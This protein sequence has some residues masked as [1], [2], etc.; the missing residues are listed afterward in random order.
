M[1]VRI[2]G[3]LQKEVARTIPFGSV[4]YTRAMFRVIALLLLLAA[5]VFGAGTFKNPIKKTDGSDPYMVHPI[6]IFCF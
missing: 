6:P 5:E 3:A 2:K 1:S 4:A